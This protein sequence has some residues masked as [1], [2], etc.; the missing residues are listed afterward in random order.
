MM[1]RSLLGIASRA[2][3]SHHARSASV[4]PMLDEAIGPYMGNS[5]SRGFTAC[6]GEKSFASYRSQLCWPLR[7]RPLHVRRRLPPPGRSHFRPPSF[8]LWRARPARQAISPWPNAPTAPFPAMRTS[9]RWGAILSGLRHPDAA[10]PATP[11][12]LREIIPHRRFRDQ[13]H[14]CPAAACHVPGRAGGRF[15]R[16]QPA[17]RQRFRQARGRCAFE[18]DGSAVSLGASQGHVLRSS[19]DGH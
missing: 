9:S 8:S 18:S 11:V 19:P 14:D 13:R 1:P 6:G 17:C 7:W 5:G 4:R 2:N 12:R 16:R 15:P 10:Q 3:R